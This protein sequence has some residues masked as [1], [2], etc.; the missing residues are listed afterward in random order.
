VGAFAV[1]A[2]LLAAIGIHGLLS[3]AVSQRT[4]EIGVRIALGATRR[5]IVG[6]IMRR[7]LMLAAIGVIL[8][9]GAAFFAGH[10]MQAILAAAT[11]DDPTALVAALA[12]AVLMVLAGSLGP[13]LRATRVDPIQAIRAERF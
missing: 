10:A 8:G 3:F 6:M 5:G 13:A 12:V 4:Q 2:L 9:A 1:I 11:P 7:G